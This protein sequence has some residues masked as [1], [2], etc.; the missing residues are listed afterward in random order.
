MYH[1]IARVIQLLV[2]IAVVVL[3]LKPA[4]AT[5]FDNNNGPDLPSGCSSIAVDEGHK[6]I[7]HVYAKGVQV[8]KWNG[9]S[10]V[11]DQPRASLFAEGN[12]FGEVGSHYKGP[13]WESK[14]GSRVTAQRVTDT[15][16]A[17]DSSAIAWLLL[18]STETTGPGIFKDVTFIQRTNTTGG[19]APADPG[20]LNEVKEVPYT[21]EYYFYRA[22]NPN[23]N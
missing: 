17:P 15:G 20:L 1:T 13:N 19:L 3:A 21:A 7:F 2:L 22:E 4:T 8:Y 11:F 14:S 9:T 12:F 23:G 6:L 10:W 16:C 18:K 5:A